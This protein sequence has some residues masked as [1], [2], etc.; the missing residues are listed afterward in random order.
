MA[1]VNLEMIDTPQAI[2]KLVDRVI[3]LHEARNDT[4]DSPIIHMSLEGVNLGR[5][6][7]VSI[8]TLLLH[9]SPSAQH[10]YLIDVHSLGAQTFSTAGANGKTLKHILQD[11]RIPKVFFDV[12]IDSVALFALYSIALEGVQDVQLMDSAAIETTESREYLSWLTACVKY[13]PIISYYQYTT[14]SRGREAGEQLFRSELGGS[15][16]V[17]NKRPLPDDIIKYCVGN[18]ACLPALR[19]KLWGGRRQDWRDMVQ[20]ETE[21]RVAYT[22]GADYQP[23][24]TDWVLAPWTDDQN[25]ALDMFNL[26]SDFEDDFFDCLENDEVEDDVE[27]G[28]RRERTT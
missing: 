23:G 14:W 13:N 18:V 20:D 27:R 28:R 11:E 25:M 7:T 12:R 4:L 16:D 19:N 24:G 1:T 10:T 22:H 3:S 5:S 2:V 17:F 21:R 6:G 26:P 8:I 15:P 9:E